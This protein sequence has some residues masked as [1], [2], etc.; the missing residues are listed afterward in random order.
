MTSK[1]MVNFKGMHSPMNNSKHCWHCADQGVVAQH[2]LPP[3]I[4]LGKGSNPRFSSN[5]C[6]P[7]ANV[8]MLDLQIEDGR[9]TDDFDSKFR[10]RH[11]QSLDCGSR[12]SAASL[13]HLCFQNLTPVYGQA[14]PTPQ[15]QTPFVIAT[16]QGTTSDSLRW[17]G[18][19]GGGYSYPLITRPLRIASREPAKG[20]GGAEAGWKKKGRAGVKSTRST[21][22]SAPP[23]P[24]VS[25]S[26]P[27]LWATVHQGPCRS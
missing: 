14:Q 2:E 17:S 19:L 11:V 26:T 1:C 27:R 5:H 20:I 22:P 16:Q 7:N 13:L 25:L 9:L 8:E 3:M 24:A 23:S 18:A 21:S 10:I 6:R 4:Q 15:T 12:R